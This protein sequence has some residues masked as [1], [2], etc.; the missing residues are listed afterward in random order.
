M[1]TQNPGCPVAARTLVAYL[2]GDLEGTPEGSSFEEHVKSCPGCHELVTDRRKAM[3]LLLS[4]ADERA[5]LET[6]PAAASGTAALF[7]NKTLLFSGGLAVVLLFVSYFMKP[8]TEIFG[9]K[10][11]SEPEVQKTEQEA[12]TASITATPAPEI[13]KEAPNAA[14]QETKPAPEPKPVEQ[15]KP[16]PG[17]EKKAETTKAKPKQ[18][19]KPARK[20]APRRQIA[21]TN[22]VEVFDE[23]GRKIG[24]SK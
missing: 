15:A 4:A 3:Q 11:I 16:Q 13:K 19:R 20:P 12:S 5:A 2:S 14:E 10:V 7:K 1:A 22:R 23:N 21:P 6:Q 9:D 24:E 18:A 17:P 8:T